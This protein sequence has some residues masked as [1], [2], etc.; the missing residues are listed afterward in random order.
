MGMNWRSKK[1][2][3][4]AQLLE[5]KIVGITAGFSGTEISGPKEKEMVGKAQVALNV[6][7]EWSA[8]SREWHT[9]EVRDLPQGSRHMAGSSYLENR[10]QNC[11][12]PIYLWI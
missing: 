8:E 11:E 5:N 12:K 9:M 10:R 3:L 4:F 2:D 7:A 1:G 6:L